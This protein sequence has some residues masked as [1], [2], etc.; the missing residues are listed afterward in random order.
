[1]SP[2]GNNDQTE[3][4]PPAARPPEA[5]PRPR[6]RKVR[7]VVGASCWVYLAVLVALWIFLRMEGDRWWPATILLFGARWPW[8]L[9]LGILLPLAMLL[10]RGSLWVLL[11]AAC[12]VGA[13][14][15]GLCV[16]WRHAMNGQA[17]GPSLSILTCNTHTSALDAVALKRVIADA[18]PQVVALQECMQSSTVAA[19]FD[20]NEWHILRDGE[21]CLASRFPVR[22]T[23]A[24]PTVFSGS[25][26]CYEIDAPG[27]RVYFINLHLISPHPAFDA[28][29]HRHAGASRQVAENSAAR[30]KQSLE[31]RNYVEGLD[32]PA[33]LAGDFNSPPDGLVYRQSW[34][35]FCNAFGSAGW[36]FGF[37]YWH[38]KR[39]QVRI[40][41]ILG[42][43]GWQ[44]EK[45]W[46]GPPVGSMHRP[47]I[48][49]MQWIGE[50]KQ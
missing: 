38:G 3:P 45:V 33:L 6:W 46:V 29:L 4:R 31:L 47:L 42:S 1:M 12:V 2:P 50:K 30:L 11:L 27:Q 40:D 7:A 14:I 18:H 22:K 26:A 24:G 13:P 49:D 15:M 21:L 36:G 39:S 32:G 10:R 19:L 20:R 35:G 43:P 25:V 5:R 44:C 48:A 41:H 23:A 17:S 8:A 28:M 34:L 16:P 9:P 37:T